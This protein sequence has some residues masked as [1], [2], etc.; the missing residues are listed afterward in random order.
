MESHC[1]AAR[2]EF[3]G[4]Q[5]PPPWPAVGHRPV[6]RHSAW[7]RFSLR[8]TSSAASVAGSPRAVSLAG[9]QARSAS[10]TDASSTSPGSSWGLGASSP[11]RRRA[12]RDGCRAGRFPSQPAVGR[13]PTDRCRPRGSHVLPR[14]GASG[15]SCAGPADRSAGP[16][17]TPS[18]PAPR[19]SALPRA[20]ARHATP[21]TRVTAGATRLHSR[22]PRHA[23]ACASHWTLQPRSPTQCSTTHLI[24]DLAGGDRIQ[25][26]GGLR[27]RARFPLMHLTRHHPRPQLGSRCRRFNASPIHPRTPW[28]DVWNGST[29]PRR[30]LR[31]QGTRRPIAISCSTSTTSCRR[32]SAHQPTPPPA[33]ACDNPRSCVQ[34]HRCGQVTQRPPVSQRRLQPIVEHVID[35]TTSPLS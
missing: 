21:L 15:S 23:H 5:R 3:S 22:S 35:Y 25:L 29:N 7:R 4:G 33:P 28:I 14:A 17:L 16:V 32:R 2:F 8:T 24:I 1:R 19:A 18:P 30:G 10:S 12:R 6:A 13:S 34:L 20:P 11:R 26:R 31:H 27:D 9:Y